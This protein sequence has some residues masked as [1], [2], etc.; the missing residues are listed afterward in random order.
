MARPRIPRGEITLPSFA[1]LADGRVRGRARTRDGID[2]VRQ[3]VRTGPDEDAVRTML[4]AE[5]RRLAY[6]GSEWSPVSPFAQCAARLRAKAD[7]R[8]ATGAIRPQTRD[9]L[10]AD[11]DVLDRRIGAVEVGSITTGS[12]LQLIDELHEKYAAQRVRRFQGLM[13]EVLAEAVRQGCIATNP[14]RELESVEV[15][16]KPPRALSAAQAGYVIRLAREWQAGHNRRTTPVAAILTLA[17]ATSLRRGELLALDRC[18]VRPPD[19]AIRTLDGQ[20]LWSV[21]VD[22]TMVSRR[23]G[24]RWRA[25]RQS[26]TKT[27]SA[28]RR[29]WLPG[30]AVPVV[31]E[32]LERAPDKRDDAPLIQASNGSRLGQ[33]TWWRAMDAF[34]KRCARELAAAGIPVG[35]RELTTHTF[36]RTTLTALGVD[37]LELAAAQAGH[38][39]SKITAESYVDKTFLATPTTDPRAAA[40]LQQAFAAAIGEAS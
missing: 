26:D 27:E 31:E 8:V 6:V 40:A 18:D 5:A 32:L 11:L 38:A 4:R 17:V 15:V 10:H 19:P 9:G 22:A 29:L 36:R 20:A 34:R 35:V 37:D 21:D 25:I 2:Q 28:R 16:R 12:L 33:Q 13:V 3:I 23:D 39:D 1:R 30:F 7:R 14:A 24:G